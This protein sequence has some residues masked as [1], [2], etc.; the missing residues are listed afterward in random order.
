MRDFANF[1]KVVRLT[2]K[3]VVKLSN[4]VIFLISAFSKQEQKG[5]GR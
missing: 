3:A 2:L 4:T 1:V 5:R